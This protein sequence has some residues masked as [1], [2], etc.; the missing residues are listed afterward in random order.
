MGLQIQATLDVKLQLAAR[1][2][3]QWGL[4]ALDARQGYRRRVGHVSG[5]RLTQLLTRLK[6]KQASIKPNKRYQA[7]VLAVHDENEELAI[8]LGSQKGKVLLQL[9]NNR[10]NPQHL[11]ATKRFQAGDIIGV[12]GEDDYFRFDG[13]PQAAMVV[14]EP[15]TGEVLAMV[16]GYDFQSGSY[17][18]AI[19]ALR[20]PGSAFKPFIYAAALD[21]KQFT[22]SSILDDAPVVFGTWEPR[23]YDGQYRGPLR[24]RQGLTYSINTVTARLLDMIKV[25][26]VQKLAAAMGITSPLINDLSLALGSS[27]VK[28]I[29]LTVAYCAIANGGFRVEPHYLLR[30]G[31]Q[32]VK[33]PNPKSVLRPEV[34]FILTSLLESVIQEGTGR[35]AAKLNRPVAGKTGTTNEQKDAWFAGFTPQMVAVVWV[36]FD[37]PQPLGKKEAGSQAALP[38]WLH[39]MQT[40]LKGQPKLPFKQPSG[41]VVQR[42]DPATGLLAPEGATD[43]MEEFFIQG[44]EPKETAQ[45]PGQVNPDTILMNPDTP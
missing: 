26:P 20:Q 12:R 6:S 37:E 4:M 3:V 31:N 42:I 21:S 35:R 43:T 17:N 1:D 40:A 10:Y 19:Q 13:G 38:V 44:T 33:R 15:Q 41:I 9:D 45:L 16:G 24:L 29:D 7:V 30:M 27:E 22:A 32:A 28:P 11:P 36:G 39:F 23:N 34:A 14:M 8:D 2:A 25:E 5:K 18:R